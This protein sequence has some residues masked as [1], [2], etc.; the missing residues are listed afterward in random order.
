MENFVEKVVNYNHKDSTT[1]EQFEE[2]KVEDIKLSNLGNTLYSNLLESIDEYG[3]AISNEEKA[4]IF[5]KILNNL[6]R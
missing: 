3:S 6:L 2:Y 1:K 5:K 4:L